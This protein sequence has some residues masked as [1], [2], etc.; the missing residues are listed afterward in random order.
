MRKTGALAV[1]IVMFLLI[2]GA[3][4]TANASPSPLTAGVELKHMIQVRDGGLVVVNDTV[5]LTNT[6]TTPIST[7]QLGFHEDFSSHLDY[8][9]AHGPQGEELSIT[10]NVDLGQTGLYGVSVIFHPAISPAEKYNFTVT[11]VFSDLITSK[12]SDHNATFP[13]YP[14]ITV[15]AVSC[16][17]NVTL[18]K[19]TTLQNSSWIKEETPVATHTEQPLPAYS[20]ETGYVS[21]T[22]TIKLLECSWTRRDIIFDPW[23]HIY[24]RDSY[25]LRNVGHSRVPT[26]TFCLPKGTRNVTAY[27]SIGSIG[28]S[29]E[30]G[31][32]TQTANATV[33]LRYPLR[34]DPHHDAYSFTVEYT[35]PTHTYPNQT[36]SWSRH[37]F[38]TKLFENF[39]WTVKEL[40]VRIVLPEGASYLA[41]HPQGN[42]TKKNGQQAITYMLR[43][44]TPLH[45]LD[46]TVEYGYIMFWSAFRPTLWIAFIVFAICAAAILQGYRKPPAPPM[47]AENLELIGS[48][49]EVCDERT[50]LR[51]ELESLKEDVSRKKIRKKEYKRRKK[52]VEQQLY[53]LDK[54]FASLKKELRKIGLRYAESVKRIEVAE[55][56]IETA[57]ADAHK[58]EI[59][60]RA[61]KVSRDAYEKLRDTYK[62]RIN[63]AKTTID[64]VIIGLKE[65]IR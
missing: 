6:G 32:E 57:R 47:P 3:V 59:Q 17:V 11:Y 28:V 31:N 40:A 41:S 5:I 4:P 14:A 27:D 42:V 22:G 1:P 65:E 2:L 20:N 33:T 24:F 10:K 12:G 45:N 60:Y 21:F 63:R 55:T 29:L 34:G 37:Q 36:E 39:D 58:I 49:V 64:D 38:K 8:V 54:E 30:A 26:L 35:A 15:S 9:V 13:K 50:A 61:G 48:F 23:G 18:P 53:T 16:E 46:L 51:A 62:K 43:N 7:F 19:G 44:V 52:V 56:E 25:N